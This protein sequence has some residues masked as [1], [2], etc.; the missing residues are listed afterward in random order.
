MELGKAFKRAVSKMKKIIFLLSFFALKTQ[1][2]QALPNIDWLLGKWEYK[3]QNVLVV[4]SWTKKN[5]GN[6][7]GYS[8]SLQGKDTVSQEV[9]EIVLEN[10]KVLYKA[11]VKEQNGGE[12][13]PFLLSQSA[14][15]SIVFV[16]EM[17]DFP[18]KIVYKKVSE[19]SIEAAIEGKIQNKI[20]R[21]KFIYLKS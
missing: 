13:I 14:S 20:K 17:H 11:T 19:T 6:Y 7:A 3:T 1:A 2:Q 4:E 12:T 8:Y 5:N 10:N 15:D 21:R 18:Q 16:N 9:V